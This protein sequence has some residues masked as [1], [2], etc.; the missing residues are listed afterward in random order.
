M[1]TKN[2]GNVKCYRDVTVGYNTMVNIWL[3][4]TNRR[5]GQGGEEE[6]KLLTWNEKEI[7]K[8]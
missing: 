2:V 3:N 8:E 5:K 4:V 6:R 7:Q 1:S